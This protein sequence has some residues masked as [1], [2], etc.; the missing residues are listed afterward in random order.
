MQAEVAELRR[1]NKDLVGKLAEAAH[2]RDSMA[3]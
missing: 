1:A 3:T 2:E